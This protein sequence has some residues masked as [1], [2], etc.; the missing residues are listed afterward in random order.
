MATSRPSNLAE[1]PPTPAEDPEVLAIAKALHGA[2]AS[3]APEKRSAVA[4][5]LVSMIIESQRPQPPK[6][7]GDVLNNVVRL[8]KEDKRKEWKAAEVVDALKQMGYTYDRKS[9]FNA[10]SYLTHGA[11]PSR[12]ILRKFGYGRYLLADGSIVERDP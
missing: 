11:D 6:R 10:L 9:V 5:L 3:V 7:G 1:K 4:D 2:L 12:R 8:F